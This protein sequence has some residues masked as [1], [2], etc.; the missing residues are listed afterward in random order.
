MVTP[1]QIQAAL[2]AAEQLVESLKTI[3]DDDK[4][5]VPL[6]TPLIERLKKKRE[7]RQERRDER[8]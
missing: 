8:K 6:L 2:E 1:A 4:I 7:E 3:D 5:E